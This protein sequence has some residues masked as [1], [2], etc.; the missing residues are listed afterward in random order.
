[1]NR[2][3]RAIKKGQRQ[4]IM[5]LI[6]WATCALQWKQTEVNVFIKNVSDLMDNF[7]KLENLK[8]ESPVIANQRSCGEQVLEFCTNRSSRPGRGFALS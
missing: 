5:A 7:L 2:K 1:V 6:G 8:L 3:T 4:I